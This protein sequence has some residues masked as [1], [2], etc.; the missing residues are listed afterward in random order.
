M[1]VVYLK[2]QIC[3]QISESFVITVFLGYFDGYLITTPKNFVVFENAS[4]EFQCSSSYSQKDVL[5]QFKPL[6]SSKNSFIDIFSAGILYDDMKTRYSVHKTIRGNEIITSLS[7]ARA[8]PSYAGSYNCRE[9]DGTG[10]GAITAEL[11]V[12]SKLKDS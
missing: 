8:D 1:I 6:N 10:R 9:K 7:I 4:V 11:T 2:V 12:I 5:W 3:M